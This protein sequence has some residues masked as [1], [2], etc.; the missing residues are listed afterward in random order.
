MK[1]ALSSA[2]ELAK[3]FEGLRLSP[4]LCPAGVPTQGYG[5][6]W[7]PDGTKVN[8][9]DPAIT[10]ATAEP[11]LITTLEDICINLAKVSPV[12]VMNENAWGAIADFVYNLGISRYKS[13]TLKKRIDKED[14]Q[15][16][17]VELLRWNRA[18]GRVLAG[19]VRRRQAERELMLQ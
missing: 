11:W 4:Y 2:V 14:F 15:G 5:T 16:A 1:Q 10:E 6:V 12:L 13:S 17:G 9:H 8:L 19:L 18:G 3:H 7:K